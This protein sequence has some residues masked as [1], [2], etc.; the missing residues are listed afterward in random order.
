MVYIHCKTA[1]NHLGKGLPPPFPI[2]GNAQI[3][4]YFCLKR[5]LNINF[6]IEYPASTK[7]YWSRNKTSLKF[8]FWSLLAETSGAATGC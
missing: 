1:A 7:L 4:E 5:G 3:H 6:I 8:C 2:L